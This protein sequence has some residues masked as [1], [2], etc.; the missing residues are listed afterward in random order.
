[1]L[2]KERRGTDTKGGWTLQFCFLVARKNLF[3]LEKP[4][5]EKKGW[6]SHLFFFLAQICARSSELSFK[7]C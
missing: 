3:L 6:F 2:D 5:Y 7:V 4:P 1:M